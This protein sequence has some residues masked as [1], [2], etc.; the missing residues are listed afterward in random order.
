VKKIP[1]KTRK[2]KQTLKRLGEVVKPHKRATDDAFARR[3]ADLDQELQRV[4]RAWLG[5]GVSSD[6]CRIK[7]RTIVEGLVKAGQVKGDPGSEFLWP[8]A[9]NAERFR[10]LVAVCETFLA[11]LERRLERAHQAGRLEVF[12]RFHG[13]GLHLESHWFLFE[14]K[15]GHLNRRARTFAARTTN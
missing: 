6:E 11:N 3:M 7:A 4:A 8:I 12:S 2:A 15:I 1:E 14:R 9:F 10:S 5:S 13:L